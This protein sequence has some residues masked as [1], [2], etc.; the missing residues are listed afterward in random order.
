MEL[1]NVAAVV[2]SFGRGVV[3]FATA[4]ADEADRTPIVW[5]PAIGE[6]LYLKHLA[7]SEGDMAFKPNSEVAG[8]TLPEL[9]GS[10]IHEADFVGENPT[11]EA[12]LYLTTPA[13][14]SVVSPGSSAHGGA[15]ARTAVAERTIV[16]LP[17]ALVLV[18]KVRV[19]LTFPG[20][21]WKI[22]GVALTAAQTAQLAMALW[23]W[24]GYFVHAERMFKGGAGDARKEVDQVTFQCMHHPDMPEGHHLYTL[25][26]PYGAGIDL[27]GGS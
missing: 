19:A 6:P 20:G 16:V 21:V 4:S 2:R 8:L 1:S 13:L 23:L 22:D 15:S 26:D 24:R 10:A 7:D 12:P 17:E 14:R 9:T 11:F 3:F 25:G 5:T 18:N 27:E